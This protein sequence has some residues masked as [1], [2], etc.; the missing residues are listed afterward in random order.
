M[1]VS[2]GA[3][4]ISRMHSGPHAAVVVAALLLAGC[5]SLSGR[6]DG[7]APKITASLIQPTRLIYSTDRSEPVMAG[8]C[9]AGMVPAPPFDIAL[10]SLTDEQI[11]RVFHVKQAGSDTVLLVTF[12]DPSGIETAEITF[13]DG[14]VRTPDGVVRTGTPAEGEANYYRFRGDPDDPRSPHVVV[15]DTTPAGSDRTYSFA[16][17]DFDGNATSNVSMFLGEAAV[18]C[19]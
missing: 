18:M 2:I 5:S 13:P 16:A 1:R 8:M 6:G 7:A 19:Q 4:P 17:R 9:P 10:Q 11:E 14:V 12:D 15:I 3:E